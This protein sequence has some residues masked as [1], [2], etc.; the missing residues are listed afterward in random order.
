MDSCQIYEQLATNNKD[1]CILIHVVCLSRASPQACSLSLSLSLSLSFYL[2]LFHSTVNWIV[3]NIHEATPNCAN[4]K[5]LK[6]IGNLCE[7]WFRH[8][9]CHHDGSHLIKF[10]DLMSK[11]CLKWSSQWDFEKSK[12]IWSRNSGFRR[13]KWIAGAEIVENVTFGETA[14]AGEAQQLV[15]AAHDFSGEL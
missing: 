1:L 11:M 8:N 15:L 7:N 14:G 9:F 6:S 3:C 13:R 12:K 5:L 4:I 10:V 2:Y